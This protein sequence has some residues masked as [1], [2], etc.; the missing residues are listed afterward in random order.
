MFL[1]LTIPLSVSHVFVLHIINRLS[2]SLPLKS[3]HIAILG[4]FPSL[5]VYCLLVISYSKTKANKCRKKKKA[6]ESGYM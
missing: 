6:N 5:I 1:N 3:L 4:C 2:Y